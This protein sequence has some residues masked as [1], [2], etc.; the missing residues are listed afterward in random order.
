MVALIVVSSQLDE[1]EVVTL[2]TVDA[3]GI[4]YENGLWVVDLDGV[5]YLRA[6]SPESY[7]FRRIQ[8]IPE[9]EL[10]RSGQH[11]EHRA[12]PIDD[13]SIRESVSRA[14][15]EKYGCFDWALVW[16]RDHSRSVPVKL[17][18]PSVRHTST[19]GEPSLGVSP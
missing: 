17:Q 3:K 5:S 14:M 4:E 2:F 8:Q 10:D 7:W 18:N 19:K 6:E 12:I 1:G 15:A 9:V 13:E 11:S 16:F